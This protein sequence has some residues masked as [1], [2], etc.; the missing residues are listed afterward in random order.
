MVRRALRAEESS[1]H[2][3][4][5]MYNKLSDV[6]RLSPVKFGIGYAAGCLGACFC[7]DTLRVIMLA[8]A[9]VLTAACFA[10][11][12]EKLRVLGVLIGMLSMSGYLW[13]YCAPLKA[14]DGSEL[15][16]ECRVTSISYISNGYSIGRAQCI[17]DGKPALITLSGNYEAEPGDILD[18]TITLTQA[19]S[20]MFTFS[21]GVI[22]EGG[23]QELHNIRN[24]FSLLRYSEKLRSAA[25]RRFMELGGD[26]A[27]LCCGLLLGQTSGF[28]LA[29]RRD[30]TYSGVNYM[31]AVSGAHITLV[32]MLLMQL[33]GRQ[34]RSQ[35]YIVIIVV[36]VLAV[37]FGFSPSVMRAG[38]MMLVSK[39]AVLFGRKAEMV[40]SLCVAFLA[41]TIFTPYAA[42]DPALL[43]S[44]LG[45][46]GVA[47]VG[48][49]VNDLHRFGFER[50]KVIAKMKEAAVLSL[51]AMVFIAPVSISCFGGISL[52]EVHASVA[53]T[54][55]FTA[56]IPLGL[57]YLATGLTAVA[58][59]LYLVMKCFRAILGFFGGISGVWLAGDFGAAVPLAFLAAVLLMIAAFY[60]D[61][62]KYA[63]QA[64]ALVLALFVCTG[65]CNDRIRHHMDFV[66]DGKSGA[67]VICT[68]N[69]ASI[70]ISG[71]GSGLSKK[72]FNEFTRSGITH[73]RLINAPQ[74]DY[75]GTV[76]LSELTE[77]FPAE[78][79][80]CPENETQHAERLLADAVIGSA[81]DT[82]TMNGR[83]ITCAKS[84]DDTA[85]GD[86]VIYWGYTRSEPKYSAGLPVY[87][88]AW[89]NVVPAGGV[90]VYDEP[91]RIDL[92]E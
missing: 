81:A 57:I 13:L 20:D 82:I 12:R 58:V 8:A 73:I 21:D 27:E 10:M 25:A 17:L 74:L 78:Q 45:V 44:V 23:I 40:N 70:V 72:L 61:W 56:A 86:I 89:Q 37:L 14:L 30:I 43:M 39:C 83:T 35:A 50:F 91:L 36:P 41:L 51:C 11:H 7:D 47:V 4:I 49:L 54:P 85:S 55:F 34:R 24:G 68:Q 67:A 38:I 9:A 32:M 60:E 59:P 15:R 53:L 88:S 64:F 1:A 75:A 28:S 79:L 65:I 18:V 76:A 6:F 71:T 69:E 16:T 19:D 90:N 2:S 29:L 31:T 66:S 92:K 48:P 46:F 22:M 84:G 42:T 63:L 52:A 77:L 87:V 26:E 33:F 3:F 80:L 5:F 62:T